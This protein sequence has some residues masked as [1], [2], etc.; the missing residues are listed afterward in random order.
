MVEL[1]GSNPLPLHYECG[2]PVP[3]NFTEQRSRIRTPFCVRLGPLTCAEVF[4]TKLPGAPLFAQADG[5]A[6]SKDYWKDPIREAVRAAGLPAKATAYTLRHSTITDLV[7]S[8][9]D[10][11]T[12]VRLAGTSVAMIEKHYAHLQHDRARDA[13][14]SLAL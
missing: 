12:V 3:A 8:G 13:L 2:E 5:R 10:L 7:T 14:A 11:I 6:W 4:R 9:L 1:R